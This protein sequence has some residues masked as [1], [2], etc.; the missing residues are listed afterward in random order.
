MVESISQI[1]EKI[2]ERP[3]EEFK[4][5]MAI[6]EL[7]KGNTKDFSKV[8]FICDQLIQGL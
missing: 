6:L 2:E 1:V 7:A 4:I 8:L 3:D 5:L